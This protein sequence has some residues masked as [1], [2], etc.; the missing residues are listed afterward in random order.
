MVKIKMTKVVF[1]KK[2]ESDLKGL[3]KKKEKR[4]AAKLASLCHCLN[5]R[6]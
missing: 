6:P 4:I 5:R 2:L 3:K 1:K